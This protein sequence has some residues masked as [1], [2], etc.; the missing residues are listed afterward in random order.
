MKHYYFLF[1]TSSD[2][3]GLCSLLA[4][5]PEAAISKANEDM[6]MVFG[7]TEEVKA[8]LRQVEHDE[9]VELC[10]EYSNKVTGSRKI[11]LIIA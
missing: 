3:H 2:I 9:F 8:P 6:R 11:N 10:I 1:G 4:V 5:N 7:L